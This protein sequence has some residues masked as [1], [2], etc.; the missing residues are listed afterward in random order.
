M[1]FVRSVLPIT[2]IRTNGV[3]RVDSITA[4]RSLVP[5]EN[6]PLYRSGVKATTAGKTAAA[7]AIPAAA[8]APARLRQRTAR[9]SGLHSTPITNATPARMHTR[10]IAPRSED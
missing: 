10:G 3:Q 1:G 8:V 7:I 4:L 6:S 2:S 9:E 5:S